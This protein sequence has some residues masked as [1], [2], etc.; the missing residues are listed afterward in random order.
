MRSAFKYLMLA[1]IAAP[2]FSLV[3][4]GQNAQPTNQNKQADEPGGPAPVRD[5]SGSW[6]GPNEASLN[7]RIPPMTPEGQAKLE[8]NIPDPFS[9][10]SNDPWKTCDPFGMPRIVNNQ[11]AQ[12]GFAQMPARVAILQ[13]QARIWPQIWP[14]PPPPPTNPGPK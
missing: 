5:L 7:N 9:A 3:V 1:L 2:A 14:H 11:I 4:L 13:Y 8:L 12:I 10:A 6:I